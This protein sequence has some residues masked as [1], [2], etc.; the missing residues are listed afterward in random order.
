MV[1]YMAAAA[2][3]LR[4]AAEQAKWIINGDAR[5]RQHLRIAL[6]YVQLAAIDIGLLPPP[7][8]P[9]ADDEGR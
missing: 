4:D 9:E 7:L 3:S 2:A 1:D 6:A 5:S 8:P